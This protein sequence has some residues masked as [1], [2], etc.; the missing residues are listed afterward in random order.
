MT[1]SIAKFEAERAAES[2]YDS[3]DPEQVNKARIAAGR[4]EAEELNTLKTLAEYENGR[5]LLFDFVRCAI[6]GNPYVPGNS[7]MTSYNLGQ[8]HKARQLLRKLM[9]ACPEDTVTM[10]EEHKEEL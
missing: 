3:S 9:I 10:I 2:Q 5:A 4:R 1:D 7:D 8:E 6:S